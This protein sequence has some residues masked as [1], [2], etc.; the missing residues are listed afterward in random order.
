[1]RDGDIHFGMWS[2]GVLPMIS[3]LPDSW[4]I[5][6]GLALAKQREGAGGVVLAFCGDGATSTGT[7]HESVNLAA[8]W[9]VPAV[10]IVEN[11]QYAYSTP[12]ALQ[13]RVLTLAERAAAYGIPGR[14]VDG[15]DVAAVHAEVA[16]AVAAARAGGGPTLIEALTM[17]MDGHAIHDPARYVPRELLEHW[18]R[19]DP[20]ELFAARL[21]VAGLLAAGA[22]EE[23]RRVAEGEAEEAYEIAAASSEPSAAD[24]ERGVFAAPP[25]LPATRPAH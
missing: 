8:V 15:N 23:L 25:Q 7:W 11:N 1:G 4:P 2:K 10:L 13:F 5:A 20:I 16:R 22:L 9:Q 3:Q 14:R 12:N 17:R 21:E 18:R 19:R 6:V 24:L